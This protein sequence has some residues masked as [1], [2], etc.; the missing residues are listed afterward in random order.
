MGVFDNVETLQFYSE[1]PQDM[2]GSWIT[3]RGSRRTSSS[4]VCV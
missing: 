1:D 3:V 4:G 2:E